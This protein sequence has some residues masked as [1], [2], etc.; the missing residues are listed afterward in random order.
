MEEESHEEEINWPELDEKGCD[1]RG[2]RAMFGLVDEDG[3]PVAI[4][5]DEKAQEYVWEFADGGR[6]ILSTQRRI[7]I[8]RGST[9]DGPSERESETVAVDIDQAELAAHYMQGE[10]YDFI[11]IQRLSYPHEDYAG[12]SPKGYILFESYPEEPKASIRLLSGEIVI[13]SED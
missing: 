13:A 5:Q 1:A 4:W 9:T 10:G 12:K 11:S 8:V 7:Y 3:R 6:E 2:R